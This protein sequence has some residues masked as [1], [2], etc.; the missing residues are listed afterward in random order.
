M[1]VF[2]LLQVAVLGAG[3]MGSGISQVS[4]SKAKHALTLMDRSVDAAA[5]GGSRVEDAFRKQVKKK[6]LTQFQCDA[7]LA[8]LKL[9]SSVADLSK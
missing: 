5:A 2:S 8:D 6:A 4:I 9:T 1:S 7:L 3:L